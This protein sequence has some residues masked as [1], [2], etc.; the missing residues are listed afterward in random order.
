[1]ADPRVERLVAWAREG[2]E[3][4]SEPAAVALQA[5]QEAPPSP[6][7]AAELARAAAA[8]YARVPGRGPGDVRS[9]NRIVGL[10]GELGEPGAR[11]LVRLRD[12]VRYRNARTT[13]EK[14]LSRVTRVLGIPAGELEDTFEGVTLDRSL[15][16]RVAVGPYT[17]LISVSGDLQ[18][19]RTTWHDHAGRPLTRRPAGLAGRRDELA[20]VDNT[21][22]RL[23]AHISA[24]RERLEQAM[25]AGRSWTGEEWAT[26]MFAD[27]LRAAMARRM[28][29]RVESA[30]AT[31]VLATYAGLR[32]VD[33]LPVSID[34]NAHLTLWH[35]ADD[36]LAQAR[37]S[38]R[39]D[40]LDINQPIAQ[41][42]RDVVLAEVDSP[43]LSLVAGHR[44]R[45]RPFRGFLRGR[46]WQIP[47]MGPWCFIP[48]ATREVTPHG[49]VAVLEVGLDDPSQD[50][51]EVLIL[52]AL[53][54]RSVLDADLDARELPRTIV[55]EAARDVLAAVAIAQHP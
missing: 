12:S 14:T 32:D 40:R 17:A 29:W 44:V 43:R 31:L 49:P 9:G 34:S 5:L 4:L 25:V 51:N 27:P 41:A 2:N 15:S 35:P 10:L 21:R 54:F 11:E 20:A 39:L 52:G 26:R 28:I 46:R 16:T 8:A 7:C 53:R 33:D 22:K 24:L 48:E 47:Y 55:S 36:L 6:A 30:R 23:R 37:W 50:D 45:Q 42:T 13:I 19:V 1:M 18:H 3:R 38:E